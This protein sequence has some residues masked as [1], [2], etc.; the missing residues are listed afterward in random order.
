MRPN[1]SFTV[2]IGSLAWVVLGGAIA[3]S[4]CSFE[5]ERV[6]AFLAV[7]A[8]QACED[9][10]D[11]VV[12]SLNCVQIDSAYCGQVVLNGT[13]AASGEWQELKSE[14]IACSGSCSVCLAQRIARCEQGLCR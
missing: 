9:V 14:A 2:S 7:S 10:D 8:N 3:C 4:D 11:C 5:A 6:E 12:E 13:A 1:A